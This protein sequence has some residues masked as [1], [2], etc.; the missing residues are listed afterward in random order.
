M[1]N[2]LGS[3]STTLLVVP[4]IDTSML[5]RMLQEHPSLPL[6]RQQMQE[7]AGD[8]VPLQ[9]QVVQPQVPVDM[10]NAQDLQLQQQQQQQQFQPQTIPLDGDQFGMSGG[11]SGGTP[12]Y[13]E[14]F[15]E[16]V[17]NHF[18]TSAV[19]NAQV[20]AA[21]DVGVN[22][23]MTALQFNLILF[24][25]MLGAY[26]VFSRLVPSVYKGR[27]QHVGSDKDLGV[28]LPKSYLPLGWILPVVRTSW[29][30]V[31]KSGGL[32]AYM[33]LRY[34]RLC[35]QISGVSA[36]WGMLILGPI[37]ASGGNQM[38]GWYKFGMANIT[39]GNWR[40]WFPSIFMW[41][42]V[43]SSLSIFP[44]GVDSVGGVMD[45]TSGSQ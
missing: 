12:H 21:S 20:M 29:T 14:G 1:G 32:D 18:G 15:I 7:M 26:E 22:T 25:I 30:T 45:I 9:G 33:F 31:R 24:V 19:T 38:D 44:F 39:T 41:F 28:D 10:F 42:M 8:M 23:A 5:D 37:F 3:S 11:M 40:L 4:D 17:R 6:S 35:L 36:I 27:R 43:S 34:I 13:Y 2:P 16:S